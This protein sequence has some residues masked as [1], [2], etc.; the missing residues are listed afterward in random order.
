MCAAV[1][2]MADKLQLCL[3]DVHLDMNTVDTI[4]SNRTLGQLD[5]KRLLEEQVA[6]LRAG[7]VENVLHV[8][9][10]VCFFSSLCVEL[11]LI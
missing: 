9:L 6:K 5:Q 4:V 7:K 8:L 1:T 10:P 11:I 2:S 3:T